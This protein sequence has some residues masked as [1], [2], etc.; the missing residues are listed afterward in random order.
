MADLKAVAVCGKKD[1]L[2]Q[3]LPILPDKFSGNLLFYGGQKIQK[4]EE[5][6]GYANVPAVL[7]MKY[8]VL[9]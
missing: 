8:R 3:F 7:S 2:K 6:Y 9:Y 4:P 5:R 1:L